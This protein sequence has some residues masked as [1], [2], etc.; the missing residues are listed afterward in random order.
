MEV[1]LVY[2]RAGYDP[3]SYLS[4]KEWHMWILIEK[5]SAIKCPSISYHLLTAKKI[6]QVLSNPNV[7]EWYV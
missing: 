7:L 4:E 2:Y 6:Q 3:V 1:G 5:S